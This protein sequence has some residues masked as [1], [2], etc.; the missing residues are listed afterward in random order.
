MTSALMNKRRNLAIWKCD[1]NLE[2]DVKI[3]NEGEIF[4]EWI[5]LLL[6][7]IVTVGTLGI[8]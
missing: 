1:K 4:I 7:V 6:A 2:N 3:M 5:I 8:S